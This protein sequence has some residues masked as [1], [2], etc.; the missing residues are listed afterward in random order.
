MADTSKFPDVYN[1]LWT[2]FFIFFLI[3]NIFLWMHHHS[4][5][6]GGITKTPPQ[7]LVEGTLHTDDVWREDK[8]SEVQNVADRDPST[9]D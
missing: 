4:F 6:K 3:F 1:P 2:F 8:F 7:Q 9:T 5:Q